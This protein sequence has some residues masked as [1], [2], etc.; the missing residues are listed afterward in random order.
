M[1]AVSI[2]SPVHNE[3]ENLSEFISR[4][5]K[6]MKASGKTWELLLI[7]DASTDNSLE[8]LK[9]FS[10]KNKQIRYV[11]HTRCM[12]QTACF[13][14][15]FKIA[16]GKIF[17]TM[18]SDIQVLPEDIPMF[19][20]KMDAGYDLVNGIRENRQHPFWMKFASRVYNTLMLVF[21]NSPVFDAA[22]N[23]TSVRSNFVKDLRLRDN[24][25]RYLIP[26]A[27]RKG[28]KKI[29]EVVVRHQIRKGGKSK[30]KALPKYIKG[31]PEI[32]L[33]WLRIRSGRYD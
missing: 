2:I 32:F 16:S 26:I 7:N 27:Q 1:I 4:V 6:V 18:D 8:I 3:E 31:T 21:F 11:S 5:T 13:Q 24:D 12:G 22:S 23:F 29:G 14:T 17:L 15:A 33:A 20:E 30:Y 25:H 9:R 19:L 10:Q 28:A